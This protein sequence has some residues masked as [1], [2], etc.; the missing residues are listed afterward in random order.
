MLFDRF[1]KLTAL[2]PLSYQY[3]YNVSK[4]FTGLCFIKNDCSFR[5]FKNKKLHNEDGPAIIKLSVEHWYL[6]GKRHRVNGPA[7]EN[8]WSN[9]NEWYLH[10]KLHREDGPAIY[11]KYGVNEWYLNGK[12]HRV[13]GPAIEYKN[14]KYWWLNDK[15]HRTDGPAIEEADGSKK[16]LLHG[17]K[18][19]VDNDFT[20]ESWKHFQRTLLF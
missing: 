10:G 18:Y 2:K 11:S 6:N 17:E 4:D 9:D 8:F 12:R 16:W 3:I 1:D 7:V 14:A 15:L 5:Y 19:G 20:N 13:N